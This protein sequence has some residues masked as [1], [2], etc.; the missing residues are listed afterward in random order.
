MRERLLGFVDALRADGVRVSVGETLDAVRAVAA[1]GV[2]R[3][4]LR[5]ALAATLLKDERDRTAFDRRFDLAFPLVGAEPGA[6]RSPRRRGERGASGDGAGR[7][8]ERGDGEVGSGRKAHV[9]TE[10]PEDDGS[11]DGRG[12]RSSVGD[13][14]SG[15]S[16]ADEADPAPDTQGVLQR[17]AR[18]AELLRRPFRE[19]TGRDV[20]EA[21]DVVGELGRRLAA[22]LARRERVA[23]RGR[24]DLRR[25]LGAARASGGVPLRLHR[26]ARRPGR[27]DLVALCDVSGSVASASELLL[28]LLA[29]AARHFRRVT[30]FA[31]VDRLCVVGIERGHLAPDGPLD[32]HARS[33]LGRVLAELWPARARLFGRSTL[34][35]VLGD[36][37]N[38]RRPPRADLLRQVRE[39]VGRLVWLVPEP[40]SRWGT[41]D[42]ALDRYAPAC[43]AVIEC[44]DVEALVAAVRRVL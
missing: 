22:R 30:T 10:A 14:K 4:V 34:L 42:S 8:G 23:K 11:R 21:R 43:D 7:G 29:P 36:G 28:G 33:D 19:L 39:R 26:R 6:G 15:V 12:A 13:G 1:A 25:T 38:N 24:I 17:S 20:V 41:G 44:T 5:D 40:R 9:G 3:A 18:N 32:L 31:Y 35:L 2:E 27:P 37:R 16:S